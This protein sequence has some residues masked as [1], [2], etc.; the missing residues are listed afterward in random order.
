MKNKPAMVILFCLCIGIAAEIP[1]SADG[2]FIE[3]GPGVGLSLGSAG[4]LLHYKK[5][6]GPLFERNSF[7][8]G[9]AAA[10][11]GINHN[12]AL[13]LAKGLRWDEHDDHYYSTT[14]GICEISRISEN[15]GRT[16]QF[17]IRLAYETKMNNRDVSIALNH[18]SD[19]KWILGWKGANN[20]ENFITISIKFL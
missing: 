12:E 6:T 4:V 18:F 8:E 9:F 5:D 20:G 13:G 11:S 15:L 19:G 7:T 2:L 16:I 10:W 3:T 17:Y 14:L 1:A